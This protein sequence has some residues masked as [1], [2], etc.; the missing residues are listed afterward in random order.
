MLLLLQILLVAVRCSVKNSNQN[1]TFDSSFNE[2]YHSFYRL[3]FGNY[4]EIRQACE[5]EPSSLFSVAGS[6]AEGP[7]RSSRRMA[8]FDND[9]EEVF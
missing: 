9:A 6:A 3:C 4:F 1:M 7:Q 2:Y 5:G 8:E